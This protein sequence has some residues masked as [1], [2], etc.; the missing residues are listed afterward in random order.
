VR[1]DAALGMSVASDRNIASSRWRRSNNPQVPIVRRLEAFTD[2]GG[3]HFRMILTPG[4]GTR[5]P[6]YGPRTPGGW[7]FQTFLNV[8]QDRATGYWDGYEFLTRDS[9]A[10]LEPNTIVLR[11]TEGGG[12][13]GGWGEEVARIP[14]RVTSRFVSFTIPLD[15]IG[16]DGMVNFTLEMYATV[17]GGED[18]ATPVASF[19]TQYTGSST[20]RSRD[21]TTEIVALRFESR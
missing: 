5:Q 16:D 7:Q 10:D 13:P 4:L 17:L 6:F 11:R 2:A 14:V 12:G 1:D 18:G 21:G 9:E 3:L 15:K 20:V 8:D 19:A